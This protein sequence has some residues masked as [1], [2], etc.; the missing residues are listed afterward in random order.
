MSYPVCVI[1]KGNIVVPVFIDGEAVAKTSSQTVMP[2]W[3]ARAE[4]DH[5]GCQTASGEITV[6]RVMRKVP[7]H[8]LQ[9]VGSSAAK[10]MELALFRLTPNPQIFKTTDLELIRPTLPGEARQKKRGKNAPAAVELVMAKIFG[11]QAAS[12]MAQAALAIAAPL[13]GEGD[14]AGAKKKKPKTA[15]SIEHLL[16]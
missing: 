5:K 6:F 7:G 2:A 3:W 10:D 8:I 15:K 4:D 14:E 1:K 9:A 12:S 16:K 11:M 13:D